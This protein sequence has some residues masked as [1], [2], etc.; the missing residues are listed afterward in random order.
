MHWLVIIIICMINCVGK[1]KGET[2]RII[3]L[4]V[5]AWLFPFEALLR[6]EQSNT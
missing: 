5:V 2:S 6:V 3:W 1:E 4:T